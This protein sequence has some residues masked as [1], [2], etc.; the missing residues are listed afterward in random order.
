MADFGLT[1]E[2]YTAPRTADFLALMQQEILDELDARGLS[3]DIDFERDVM[4]G[5]MTT[6]TANRLGKL[7]E[8]NQA[9]YN[10]F[11]PNNAGGVQLDS[12]GSVV[13]VNRLEATESRVTLRCG[14]TGAD[15][16]EL[17]QGSITEGGGDDGKARWILL[18]DGTIPAASTVD[19]L[20]EAQEAG[21]TDAAIGEIDTIVTPI[22]GWETVT[23]LAAATPGRD[24]E[25]DQEY[26]IRRQESLQITG[27]RS[28][29]AL[30]AQLLT[31]D[32]VLGAGVIDNDLA[33]SETV[34]GVTLAPHS[35]AV[36]IHPSTITT[37]EKQAI[38]QQ[39]Y[40]QIAAGIDTNGTA[41]VA[42]VTGLDGPLMVGLVGARV[43]RS[44]H[45]TQRTER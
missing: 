31:L 28:L 14:T 23:N 39:I 35:V 32:G 43:R 10:A 34:E 37:A 4:W 17:T 16:V 45:Q 7:G 25:T 1:D 42:T 38:A 29:N 12:L 21:E 13:G 8:G 19:L 36:F 2:G 24:R 9:V 30:R 11:D 15:P 18:A 44:D 22:D 26:R 5:I 20:F 40:D 6:V 3:T 41:V 27:G 33:T